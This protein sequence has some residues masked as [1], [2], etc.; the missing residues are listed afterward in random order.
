[1]RGPWLSQKGREREM[2]RAVHD[3]LIS[4]AGRGSL[5]PTTGTLYARSH[6]DQT[7][8]SNKKDVKER[9]TLTDSQLSPPLLHV[10]SEAPSASPSLPGPPSPPRTVKRLKHQPPHSVLNLT[11]FWLRWVFSSLGRGYLLCGA[12]ASHCRAS[13]A[14]SAG[15]A[16]VALRRRCSVA[17][18]TSPDRIPGLS[19]CPC[20]GGQAGSQ[21]PAPRRA[22]SASPPLS[23][24]SGLSPASAAAAAPLTQAWPRSL[25]GAA[26]SRQGSSACRARAPGHAGSR[27]RGS[28]AL[29]TGSAVAGHRLSCSRACGLFPN[30]GLNLSLLHLKADSLPLSHQGSP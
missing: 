16:A 19:L 27:N 5:S 13:L 11:Y 18:V 22:G 29:D 10:P 15:S 4:S 2:R 6:V 20:T 7:L 24:C 25:L 9:Q 8:H 12:R 1:M 23:D 3:G 28:Q 30:E 21:P 26:F 17:S 14:G